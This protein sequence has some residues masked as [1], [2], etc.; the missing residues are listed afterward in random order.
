MDSDAAAV[1]RFRGAREESQR[2]T[3]ETREKRN[4]SEVAPPLEF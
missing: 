1:T 3:G 4:R 2:E